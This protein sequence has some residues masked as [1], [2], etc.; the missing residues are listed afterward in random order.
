MPDSIHELKI[1]L[2]INKDAAQQPHVDKATRKLYA[3]AS[4]SIVKIDID[5][6]SG[7]GFFINN[8]GQIA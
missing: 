8:K 7:S 2:P 3:D 6:G 4:P 1:G 5:N